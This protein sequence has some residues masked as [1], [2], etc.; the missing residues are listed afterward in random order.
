MALTTLVKATGCQRRCLVSGDAD[1]QTTVPPP[2]QGYSESA[3]GFW[4]ASAAPWGWSL[5]VTFHGTSSLISV[6][7]FQQPAR[8]AE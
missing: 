1:A 6:L 8:E 7:S 4:S 3:G 2:V 5:C